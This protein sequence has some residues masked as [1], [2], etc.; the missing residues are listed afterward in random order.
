MRFTTFV[1]TLL[2]FAVAPGRVNA[3]LQMRGWEVGPWAGAAFYLGDLNTDFR[4]NRPGI[5][6][7]VMGRYN[8]NHRLAARGS[9]NYGR[10]MATDADS[11]NT[12][13]RLRNLNFRSQVI[14]LS[15]Q[16]E[17]NF[18]PYYHGSPEYFFTPYG[19][20]GASLFSYTPKGTAPGGQLVNLRPLGTEGQIGRDRYGPV[21]TALN[22][23][24]GIRWDLTY[25]LSMDAH[26]GIRNTATD[27]LDDVSTVY[28][29]QAELAARY[30]NIASYLSDPSIT[31]PGT[32]R[33][34][35]QE[36]DQRGDANTNDR[37]LFLGLG[38]NYYFGDVI[39]PTVE[40]GKARRRIKKQSKRRAKRQAKRRKS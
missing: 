18:L 7:G 15:A 5:A 40:K 19:F 17:F 10:V 30:G 6:G 3:Q 34:V 22:Y 2:V 4:F 16:F 24:I 33:V 28:P 20:I 21:S 31:P 1:F 26:L 38:I 25:A 23:G 32:D 39:C 13:E 36:G 29:D 37:Y 8:F 11:K 12:F 27:Y 35:R 14:D 9:V